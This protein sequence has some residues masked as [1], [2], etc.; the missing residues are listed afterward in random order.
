M[1]LSLHGP[2]AATDSGSASGVARPTPSPSGTPAPVSVAAVRSVGQVNELRS[3]PQSQRPE[4]RDRGSRLDREDKT[5]FSRVAQTKVALAQHQSENVPAPQ[6][7]LPA[8]ISAAFDEPIS[9]SAGPSDMQ[10]QPFKAVF[11]TLTAKVQF[12]K[13][14]NGD[15]IVQIVDSRTQEV[16]RQLPAEALLKLQSRLEQINQGG[17]EKGLL[18][19]TAG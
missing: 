8:P 2:V 10:L 19:E 17:E 4:S 13:S 12:A 7:G 9:E 15:V 6:I 18:L 14:E 1:S 3:R 16:V 5:D 11:Q